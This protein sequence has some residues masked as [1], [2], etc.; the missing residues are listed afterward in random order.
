VAQGLKNR[1]IAEMLQIT[2][3]TVKVYFHRLFR[4]LHVKS[5]HELAVFG[6]RHLGLAAKSE[7]QQE[8]RRV[9]GPRTLFEIKVKAS[10]QIVPISVISNDPGSES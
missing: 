3:S 2:E 5:R 6:I 7:P 9:V 10:A 8:K 1:E 4:K